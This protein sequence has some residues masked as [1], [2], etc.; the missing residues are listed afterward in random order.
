M[1]G[2]STAERNALLDKLVNTGTRYLALHSGDPGQNGANEITTN[3][4]ARVNVSSSFPA[5]SG[6]L[7]S[8][9]VAITYPAVTGAGYTASHWGL[10]DASTSGSFLAGGD[11]NP[12]LV[13][14]AGNI[15]EIPVGELDLSGI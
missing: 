4:A 8:N 10:W 5:A 1:A 3:G 14:V 7:V 11:I 2:L 6:G 9:D 12:D 15:P 13:G